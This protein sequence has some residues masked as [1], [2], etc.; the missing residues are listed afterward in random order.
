M[1]VELHGSPPAHV[2]EVLRAAG[3]QIQPGPNAVVLVWP[4]EAG[5]AALR[6]LSA[7]GQTG[8][9]LI[10]RDEQ[11]LAAAV[12]GA[13]GSASAT[14]PSRLRLEVE[15]HL[16]F[17]R[18]LARRSGPTP[19]D[20]LRAQISEQLIAVSPNPILCSDPRGR[21]MTFSPAAERSLG[22]E[23]EYV[24][25]EL[26]VSDLYADPADA[27]RV[28]AEIRC[29]VDGMLRDLP[30]RL[31]ARSGEH[32]PVLL[33]AAEVED[34]AGQLLATVG[35]FRDQRAEQGLRERLQ[36]ATRQLIRSERRASTVSAA[37]AAAHE[38]NQPLTALMGALEMLDLRTDLPED[39]QRR[40]ERMYRQMDR[41]AE[42]VRGL[43][44]QSLADE[45]AAEDDR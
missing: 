40:L 38:L 27:R 22:Y 20:L 42:I 5:L 25:R 34:E 37:K 35:M 2:T 10:E 16:R 19:E 3:L 14:D 41:M 4:D 23:A 7:S 1:H 13:A 33:S 8:L 15:C 43:G 18:A 11:L 29:S 31:R 26:H 12:A 24:I 30:V 36:Q 44:Q 45:I 6:E 39:V 21:I 9:A 28:L 17:R 32:I